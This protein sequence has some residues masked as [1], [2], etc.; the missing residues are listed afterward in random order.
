MSRYTALLVTGQFL[1]EVL[2]FAA[3]LLGF[4]ALIIVG[5]PR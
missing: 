3:G 1:L 5:V 2:V 4:V